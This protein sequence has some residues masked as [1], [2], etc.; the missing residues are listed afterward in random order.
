LVDTPITR[1]KLLEAVFSVGPAPRLYNED[2]RPPERI[3]E[4]QLRVVSSVEL[5]K[6]GQE[7]LTADKSSARAA[8]IKGSE[9]GKLKNLYC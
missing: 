9:S 6:G 3:I 4:R 1:W 2:P 7:V 5:G 8:V